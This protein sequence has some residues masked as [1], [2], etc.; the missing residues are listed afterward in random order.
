MPSRYGNNRG[1]GRKSSRTENFR[2]NDGARKHTDDELDYTDIQEL[3]DDDLDYDYYDEYNEYDDDNYD[4]EEDAEVAVFSKKTIAIVA[5]VFTV[6]VLLAMLMIAVTARSVDEPPVVTTTQTTPGSQKITP[7]ISQGGTGGSVSAS[8][9]VTIIPGYVVPE[10]SGWTG[11]YATPTAIPE[12]IITPTGEGETPEITGEVTPEGTITPTG[13]GEIPEITGDA[14]PE[15]T[16]TPTG[17]G[18]IPGLTGEVTPEPQVTVTST[19][20]PTDGTQPTTEP[21]P[22]ITEAVVPTSTPVPVSTQAPV[23]TEE[24]SPQ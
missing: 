1:A 8:L 7:V 14:I 16:I 15:G 4:I 19:P 6:M 3:Y 12:G 17:E 10:D 22:V 11:V 13:E 21:T 18:E 9:N 2:E 23:T 20:V 24:V 5:G